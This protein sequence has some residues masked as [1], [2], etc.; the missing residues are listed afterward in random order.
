[1]GIHSLPFFLP[2]LASPI[3]IILF[4]W[5][6]VW[7][8]IGLWKSARNNQL[9]WFIAIAIFNT[10]GLLPIVYILFFQRNK[11]VKK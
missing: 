2:F 11:K 8:V 1:M 7:K 9:F 3:I 6:S 10:V 5:D 4:I